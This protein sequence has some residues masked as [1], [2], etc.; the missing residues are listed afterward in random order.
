MWYSLVPLFPPFPTILSIVPPS[1]FTELCFHFLIFI[2]SF[3]SSTC[4]WV[5][6]YFWTI[7]SCF[8]ISVTHFSSYLHFQFLF[9]SLFIIIFIYLVQD[10]TLQLRLGVILLFS[11]SPALRLQERTTT[12]PCLLGPLCAPGGEAGAACGAACAESVELSR[13]PTLFLTPER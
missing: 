1:L 10:L 12:T 2:F 5:P 4:L 6:L 8:T 13:W 11:A 7:S 3:L 9:K